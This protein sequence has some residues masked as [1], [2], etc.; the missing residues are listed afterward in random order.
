MNRLDLIATLLVPCPAPDLAHGY[1]MRPCGQCCSW[2]C[3]ATM[4]AWL[5][6]GLDP[7]TE[8][9]RAIARAS[10]ALRHGR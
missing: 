4:A 2:P 7:D 6:R 1:C 10:A 9:N 3:P 5:A 8:I